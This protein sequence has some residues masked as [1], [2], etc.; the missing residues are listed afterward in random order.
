MPNLTIY[1]TSVLNNV[2][3]YPY[4]VAHPVPPTGLVA[5]YTTDPL[6]RNTNLIKLTWVAPTLA[7]DVLNFNVYRNGAI[8]ATV[9]NVAPLAYLDNT[10]GAN[11]T[12]FTYYATSVDALGNESPVSVSICNFSQTANNYIDTL[13]R[14]LKDNPADPRVQRWTDDDLWLAIQ[15]GLSRVNA[16]PMNTSF[17][18]DTAPADL[19]NYIIVASRIAALRSQSSLEVAKEF[20]MGV[21]GATINM[22]RSS[23]Y[24]SLVNAEDAAFASEIKSIKLNFTMRTVHGEGI[25]TSTMPFK[26][27][28]FSPRQYRVR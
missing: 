8:I 13:R 28:T 10:T 20:S 21:G 6:N 11:V 4:N 5:T 27:R 16:I 2:V 26:I 18:L 17:N 15:Q 24:N 25:L 3:L 1:P 7:P 22:N 9:P 19:F 12:F 23:A 14:S